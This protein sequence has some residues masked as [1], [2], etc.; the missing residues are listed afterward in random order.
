[1]LTASVETIMSV[2]GGSLLMGSTDVIGNGI[3]VDSREAEPGSVY[4]ALPGERVDGHDFLIDVLDAGARVLVVTRPREELVPVLVRASAKGASVLRVEDGL[5]ALQ[6]LAS[7]HRGRLHATVIGITGSTGKTTTKDFLTAVLSSSMRV[8]STS[9]NRNNELG[10]PLTIFGAGSDTDALVVEM[11]MRGL[12]QIARLAEIARPDFGLVTNVGTSHLEI[13][14]TQDA[15]AT[16]KGEL[17]RAL[18]REGAAFL[19]GDDSYSD[20]L[21]LDSAAPVTTYG[22]SERCTVRAVDIVLDEMS[23]PSFTLQ[24]PVGEVVVTL[25]ISGR[26]NVYNALA[27]AAVGLR[28]A[29]PLERIGEALG[30][31]A[32]TDMRMQTFTTA[33]GVMVVND[34]YNANPSSMRAALEALSSMRVP[35]RRIAVVG[36]MAELGSLSELAHFQIGET[37]AQLGVDCLVTVGDRARRIADGARAEGMSSDAV[38]ACVTADEAS[39]VLDDLLEAGD[40]VLVKASRVMGL[41]RVVEGIVTP[42]VG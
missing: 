22:L 41:E 20:A 29:V 25:A 32:V 9:G 15:V 31:A 3:T 28:M 38:R 14:G 30:S 13:L 10:L 34:A 39:E 21:A 7:W 11:G 37:V 42:R 8:V 27:A 1:M 17:I 12:G 6:A 33:S 23:R 19:N 16:A 36:D 2:C 26:H 5:A 24:T 18:P 4:F 35:G 40:V